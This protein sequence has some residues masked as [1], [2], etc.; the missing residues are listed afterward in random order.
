SW[1]FVEIDSPEIKLKPGA[2]LPNPRLPDLGPA[3]SAASAKQ[4]I[5][6]IDP[7]GSVANYMHQGISLSDND[8]FSVGSHGL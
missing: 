2:A 8:Y 1:T 4:V 6:D 5:V 7:L 3:H